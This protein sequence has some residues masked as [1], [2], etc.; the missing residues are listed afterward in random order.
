MWGA[1]GLYVPGLSSQRWYITNAQLGGTREFVDLLPNGVLR[2]A[3]GFEY[4]ACWALCR[5]S[6]AFGATEKQ[7]VAMPSGMT[8]RQCVW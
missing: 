2:T 3:A 7:R 8:P 6:R 4:H 5:D 1:W